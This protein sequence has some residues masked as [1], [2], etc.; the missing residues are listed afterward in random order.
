MGPVENLDFV[1]GN[2]DLGNAMGE[3]GQFEALGSMRPPTRYCVH[4]PPDGTTD[5]K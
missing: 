5:R 1:L 3:R 2:E 4:K